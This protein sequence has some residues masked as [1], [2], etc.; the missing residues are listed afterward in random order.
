MVC[1]T[2][3]LDPKIL[4]RLIGIAEWVRNTEQA[5]FDVF[6]NNFFAQTHIDLFCET[7]TKAEQYVGL[8]VSK[9]NKV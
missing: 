7:F 3:V 9:G 1:G 4:G 5:M 8:N 6:D 2:P